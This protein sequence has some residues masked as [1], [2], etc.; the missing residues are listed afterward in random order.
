MKLNTKIA[1]PAS[2]SYHIKVLILSFEEVNDKFGIDNKA[3]SKIRIEDM[4]KKKE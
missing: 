1:Q 3:M 2:I 4:V